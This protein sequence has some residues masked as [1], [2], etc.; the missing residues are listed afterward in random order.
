MWCSV[1]DDC[2]ASQENNEN[3]Q[4]GVPQPS[5]ANER[6]GNTSFI[7]ARQL[8]ARKNYVISL[9]LSI[10]N[11]LKQIKNLA[12]KLHSLEAQNLETSAE[13]DT[14]EEAMEQLEADHYDMLQE[15]YHAAMEYMEIP[16]GTGTQRQRENFG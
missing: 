15:F 6:T 4:A 10:T 14:T 7:T 9:S 8:Q 2:G 1:F 3:T 16:L 13:Y 12:D 5:Q 11:S